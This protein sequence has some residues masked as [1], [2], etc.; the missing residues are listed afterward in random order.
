MARFCSLSWPAVAG[1][2][3]SGLVEGVEDWLCRGGRG[4]RGVGGAIAR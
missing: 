3:E 2:R 4:E 1:C